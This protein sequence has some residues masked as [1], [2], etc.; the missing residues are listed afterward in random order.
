MTK[1]K[2]VRPSD[3]P[4][5]RVRASDGT[6]IQMK[7]V[8]ADS[9]TFAQDMLAAFRSNVRRIKTEQRKRARAEQDAAQA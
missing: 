9:T 8:Q 6:I 4:T 7:V 5:K 1:P 2:P 3:L